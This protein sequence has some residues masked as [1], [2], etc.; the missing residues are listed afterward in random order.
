[1]ERLRFYD[2]V[3]EQSLTVKLKFPHPPLLKTASLKA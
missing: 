2:E 3:V 1:M